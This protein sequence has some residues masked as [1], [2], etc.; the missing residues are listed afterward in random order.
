MY[1]SSCGKQLEEEARFCSACGTAR[2]AIRRPAGEDA[3]VKRLS[4]PRDGQRIAGVCAGV[5]RYLEI[6]VTLVRILWILIA[7]CP[8]IPGLVGYLVCWIVM[9]RDAEPISPHSPS[10]QPVTVL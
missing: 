7:I 2:G 1:C 9:P 4:R 8:A 3:G 5:A 10:S 6:D